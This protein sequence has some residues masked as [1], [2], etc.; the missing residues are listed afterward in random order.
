LDRRHRCAAFDRVPGRCG[1]EQRWQH[2][3]Q[4][5]RNFDDSQYA[6]AERNTTE[7]D[8]LRHIFAAIVHAGSIKS[9]NARAKRHAI[10]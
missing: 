1:P 5:F 6:C 2:C 3:G 10:V 8:R 7:H 9:A 4:R